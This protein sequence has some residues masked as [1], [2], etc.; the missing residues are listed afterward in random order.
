MA[1]ALFDVARRVL[2]HLRGT[3]DRLFLANG[4]L[5]YVDVGGH[6]ESGD[7]QNAKLRGGLS[8]T[9]R[10]GA[11]AAGLGELMRKKHGFDEVLV[12][13]GN[14]RLPDRRDLGLP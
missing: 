8:V 4:A 6:P 14:V 7:A 12:R 13:R 9:S 1:Q 10:C 3:G 2:V 5:F 11:H